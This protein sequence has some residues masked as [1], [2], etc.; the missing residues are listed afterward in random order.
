MLLGRSDASTN[1][2]EAFEA[3]PLSSSREYML[4]QAQ[5]ALALRQRRLELFGDALSAEAPFAMLLALYVNEDREPV[6]TLTR[7]TQLSWVNPSTAIRWLEVLVDDGWI[8]RATDPDDL[9]KVRL[10]MSTKAR[11]KLDE[12]FRWT[13]GPD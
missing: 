1:Q 10:S 13:V 6:L 5:A 2:Q 7:L 4:Q 3:T 12:L 9:R 11:Q 8:D